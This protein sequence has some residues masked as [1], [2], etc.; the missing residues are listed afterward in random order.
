MIFLFTQYVN[1]INNS[2]IMKEKS[3]NFFTF[4]EDVQVRG[5]TH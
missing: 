2:L 4:I 3:C 5:T 1:I